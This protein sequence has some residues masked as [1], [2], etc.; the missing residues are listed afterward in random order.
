M[1]LIYLSFLTLVLFATK[2]MGQEIKGTVKN[3]DGKTIAYA[4]IYIDELQT[5]TSANQRGEY[6]IHVSKGT[7]TITFRSLGYSPTVKTVTVNNSNVNLDV[8]LGIQSYILAGVTVRADSEDPAYSIMRKAIARTPRFI[9]QAK[10]YTSEVYIKAAMKFEKLPRII[11]NR[12]EMNG[13][14]PKVNQTYVNESVNKITF[15]A[16]DN[17]KQEVISVNNS[18]P[19]GDDDVPVM[20]LISGSI[21]QS[22]ENMYISPFAPNSFSHYRFKHEGILQDGALFINKIKVTPKRKNKLLISGYLYIIDELW[23]LYSYDIK[24]NPPFSKINVKQHFAPVKGNNY[25]PVNMFATAKFKAMGVRASGTYTTTI[26]YKNVKINPNFANK[27]IT[28]TPL[29]TQQTKKK[30]IKNPKLKEVN[31]KIEN[32]LNKEE[33]S[34]REMVKL[35]KLMSKKAS[36]VENDNNSLEIKST[37]DIIANKKALIRDSIY[38]DSIRPIPATADEKISYKKV[39]EKQAKED[40]ASALSKAIKTIVFGN[41]SWHRHKKTHIYYPGIISLQNVGFHPVSGFQIKQSL[42]LRAILDTMNKVFYWRNT[43]RY[44]INRKEFFVESSMELLYERIKRG[45]LFLKGEYTMKDFN[46][47]NGSNPN[48]NAIYNL[49]FKQNYIK[50]Y[51]STKFLLQHHIDIVNGLSSIVRVEWNKAS[52]VDNCTNY[53]FLFPNKDY[54]P[55][56]PINSTIN[57]NHL[58]TKKAFEIGFRLAHTPKQYFRISSRKVKYLDKSKYPT[59]GFSYST[60]IKLNNEYANYHH[61]ELF[62][63]QDIDIYTTSQ[64]EYNLKAGLFTKNNNLHFSSF[65]HFKTMQEYFTTNSFK[66]SFFLI[67]NY[68]YSTA[69]KYIEAHLKYTNDFLLLKHLPI[70]SNQL[71]KENLYLNTLIVDKH[72]PYYEFG[73]SMSQILFTGEIGVFVGFKGNQFHQVGIKGAFFIF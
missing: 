32:L 8:V 22:V 41:S 69:D 17:Y 9:N 65:K 42:R 46:N 45:R 3:N 40:S 14:K 51:H 56:I 25:F 19:M 70:I 36:M 60:A 63:N 1:R 6:S 20:G 58:Q 62:V 38:W 64:F 24:I 5:G 10:T 15:T 44:A 52:P 27:Q 28:H 30:E 7:F 18:F 26:K 68:E 61:L 13:E 35:Q 66:N 50:Q 43:G 37:Y 57:N 71:W 12:L 49:F 23:C 21:Y 4:T 67:N 53:S 34:N 72:Y 16:P 29:Q 48:L 39:E 33:L 59:Y 55:N 31:T 2:T 47:Y 54:D 73:Y 11:R